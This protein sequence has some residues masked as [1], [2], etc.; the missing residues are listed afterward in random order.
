MTF[1]YPYLLAA[2][3]LLLIF[4]LLA[5]RSS[6]NKQPAVAAPSASLLATLPRSMR[7]RLR[8]PTLVTLLSGCVVSLSIAAARPQRITVLDSQTQGRNIMLVVDV[9]RSMGERDFP[10]GIGHIT[11][12]DGLKTVVAEYV[13]NRSHDRVG[14]VVFG[15]SAYLQSPL[16]TDL[17]LVEQF[18]KSLQARMAGDGTAIGDGLGL[19]LKRLKKLQ[20]TSRAIILMTDGVNTAGQIQPLKAASVAKELGIQVHTVGIGGTHDGPSRA[21][22]AILTLGM[23]RTAEFDE[24]TLKKIA[25][26]TGGVYFNAASLSGFKEVYREIEKL[27]QTESK[28]QNNRQVEELFQPWALAAFVLY[29]LLVGLNSTY[30]RRVP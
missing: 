23:S 20:D 15:Q 9:S 11:R 10:S 13:K 22:D 17:A 1:A 4:S 12:L 21:V 2:G 29:A 16:T 7:M 18:V 24:Q 25:D 8:T 3:P 5:A 26:T 6:R 30:F 14:L 19:A 27:T 28:L